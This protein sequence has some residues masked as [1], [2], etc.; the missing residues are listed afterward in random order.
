MYTPAL[1]E[2]LIRKLY[3]LKQVEKRPMTVLINEAV[4]QYLNNIVNN[5]NIQGGI[6]GTGN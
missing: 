5:N 4:E 3:Q 2:V 6:N 1:S